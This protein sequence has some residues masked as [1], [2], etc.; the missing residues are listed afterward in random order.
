MHQEFLDVSIP[1]N[2]KYGKHL[3]LEQIK[4][5]YG[6]KEADK[7]RVV[8]FFRTISEAEVKL[9]ENGDIMTVTAS[10]IAVEQALCT[11]L[12][13]RKHSNGARAIRA[14]TN[15]CIPKD[16]ASLVSFI[17]LNSPIS[18]LQPRAAKSHR[19][20]NLKAHAA[21]AS[22]SVTRGNE[23]AIV[24]FQPVCGN[25]VLNT[26]SPP[27]SNVGDLMFIPDLVVSVN[28]LANSKTDPYSLETDPLVFNL[29]SSQITCL[30]SSTL[31]VPCDGSSSQCTCVA[32]VGCAPVW[33]I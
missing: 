2:P 15:L 14:D 23:E 33:K 9:A 1:T 22:I 19:R 30:D 6:P 3:T 17:S 31:S 20:R 18:H 4:Q 25:G 8:K 24:R 21:Q 32:K 28:R 12:S 13:Y 7:E 27:C 10:V 29:D 26:A 11:K 5:K 16:I